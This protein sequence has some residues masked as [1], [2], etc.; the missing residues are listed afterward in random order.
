MWTN[1]DPTYDEDFEDEVTDADL[2]GYNRAQDIVEDPH[3]TVARKR[4]LLAHWASDV[5]AVLGAP[6]LRSVRGITITIDSIHAAM[7]QLDDMIDPAAIPVET[8]RSV[9]A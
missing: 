1:V 7:R 5:H 3:L 6:A 8:R 9:A 2:L 4:E